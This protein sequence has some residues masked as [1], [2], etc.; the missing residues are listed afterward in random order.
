MSNELVPITQTHRA[1]ADAANLREVVAD[2]LLGQGMSAFDLQR[3]KV[4]AGGSPTFTVSDALAGDTMLPKFEG[5][6]VA[7]QRPRAYWKTQDPSGSP[8]DCSSADGLLGEGDNGIDEGRRRCEDCPQSKFGT[9]VRAGGELG[10]GQACKQTARLFVLRMDQRESIFPSMLGVPPGSLK[11]LH[12]YLAALTGQNVP[13]WA[14]V[15]SF[16]VTQEKNE[17]GIKYGQVKVGFV[18]RL[19]SD[20]TAAV[21][22]YQAAMQGALVQHASKLAEGVDI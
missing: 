3:I 14:A 11:A 8:P 12:K 19:N 18:R 6:I 17:D 16:E 13:Y 5:V 22:S 15:H 2:N 4:A 20:E 7:Q 21:R 1:L 10:R 9:A